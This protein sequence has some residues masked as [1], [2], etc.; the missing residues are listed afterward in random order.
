MSP[1]YGIVGCMG[2]TDAAGLPV[3]TGV[4][5]GA[6]HPRQAARP[7]PPSPSPPHPGIGPG[8]VAARYTV[9][10]VR[11]FIRWAADH[12]GETTTRETPAS[13]IPPETRG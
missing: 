11:Q 4:A 10:A 3:I 2:I 1:P 9:A 12:C 8:W 6:P 7:A 5:F 13:T